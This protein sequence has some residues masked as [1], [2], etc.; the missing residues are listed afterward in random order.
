[1]KTL[2]TELK[3]QNRTLRQIKRE[4]R[5][6]L[7]ELYGANEMLYGYELIII[8]VH[9]A[10]TIQGRDYP[11]REGYPANEDWGTLAWSFGSE[12]REKAHEIYHGLVFKHTP[13]RQKT[14]LEPSEG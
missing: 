4:G 1:M 3:V 12:Q 11:E 13:A 14:D 6:A 5:V 7:Y 10:Q 9:P 8:K 2:E